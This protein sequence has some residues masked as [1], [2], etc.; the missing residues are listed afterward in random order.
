MI[1]K[2]HDFP[3]VTLV[4]ILAADLSLYAGNYM[5]AEKTFQLLVQASG[6]AGRG[7]LPGEVV[8]QTY[9]PDHYSIVEASKSS[10]ID[11]IIKKLN[12]GAYLHILLYLIFWQF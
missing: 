5:A 3:N 1:I 12:I 2:G 8:I 7:N 6:R 4:G 9:N 10:Y 11:F